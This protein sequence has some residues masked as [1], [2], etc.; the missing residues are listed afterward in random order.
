VK[1]PA[2]QYFRHLDGGF[3]RFV[4]HARSADTEGE[5][6]IYEH[7]WPFDQSLWVRN[8]TDFEARFSSI[9][10]ITVKRAMKQDRAQAQAQ[11]NAAKAARRAA[12]TT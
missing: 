1:S 8:R 5:V 11:V 4:S 6:V 2:E 10:E 3:Y 7:L 12:K 9:D